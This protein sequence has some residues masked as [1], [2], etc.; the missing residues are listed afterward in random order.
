[1]NLTYMSQA[2]RISGLDLEYFSKV[3]EA[4]QLISTILMHRIPSGQVNVDVVEEYAH[5]G[6]IKFSNLLFTSFN[7]VQRQ[8]IV[9]LEENVDPQ[10]LLQRKLP[11]RLVHT[12]DNVVQYWEKVPFELDGKR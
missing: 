4:I 9:A 10:G 11:R 6:S 5:R 2:V 8:D 3:I 7:L 1:M 12:V